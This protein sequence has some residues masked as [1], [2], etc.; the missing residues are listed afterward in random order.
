ME[1]IEEILNSIYLFIIWIINIINSLFKGLV[2][3]IE[4][5]WN[6]LEVMTN[7]LL[8]LPTE[9]NSLIIVTI[10]IMIITLVY[11]FVR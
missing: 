6:L 9:I 10:G 2:E 1:K 11:K 8:N 4:F 5:T 3:I 7:Y